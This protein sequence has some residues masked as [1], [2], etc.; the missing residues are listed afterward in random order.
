VAFVEREGHAR[1]PDQ[2]RKDGYR[3]GTWVRK[4]RGLFRRG[5]LRPSV[6]LDSK[7]FRDGPGLTTTRASALAPVGRSLAEHRPSA[8]L[9]REN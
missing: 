1:V 3:L 6:A 8:A 2:W 5:T 4:Q 9:A 7:P